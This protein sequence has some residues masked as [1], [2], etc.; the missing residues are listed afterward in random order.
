MNT[1]QF[2]VLTGLLIVVI[3]FLGFNTIINRPTDVS[4]ETNKAQDVSDELD[5]LRDDIAKTGC[6]I[7]GESIVAG[8]GEFLV[9]NK[10][11]HLV[12]VYVRHHSGSPQTVIEL[13]PGS[14]QAVTNVQ[15]GKMRLEATGDGFKEETFCPI[16]PNSAHE[17]C[18]TVRGWEMCGTMMRHSG[19]K[20]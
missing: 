12:T 1:T 10:T 17:M 11:E 18:W 2:R 6:P 20:I 16:L 3:V 9:R 13:D 15:V 8:H 14:Y 5:K 7:C 19:H 4:A